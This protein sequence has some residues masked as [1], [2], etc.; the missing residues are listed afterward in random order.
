MADICICICVSQRKALFDKWDPNYKSNDLKDNMATI[1]SQLPTDPNILHPNIPHLLLFTTRLVRKDFP[2]VAL[3][4]RDI[5]IWCK[6][7]YS[8][9]AILFISVVVVAFLIAVTC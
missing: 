1:M 2:R 9:S 6:N 5:R 3:L 7:A 8:Q 4:Q